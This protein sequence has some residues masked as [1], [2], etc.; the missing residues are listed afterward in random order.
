MLRCD[1]RADPKH[2]AGRARYG[3]KTEINGVFSAATASFPGTN[4][5]DDGGPLR[6]SDLD[7]FPLALGQFNG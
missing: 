7:V 6:I 1:R 3:R 2:K 5:S 4:S